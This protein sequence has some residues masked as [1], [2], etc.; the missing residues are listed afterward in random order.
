M[1]DEGVRFTDAHSP[2]TICSP[3][4]YGLFSGQH[5]TVLTG[6]GGGAFEGPGGPS[7]LK[8]G[9]LTLGDM[10]QAKGIPHRHLRQVACRA[11]LAGQGWQAA[12]RRLRERAAD[13]LRKEHAADRWPNRRGFHESL[14]TPN[15]P[16]TDPLYIYI[17][18]GR[19]PVP[20]SQRHQPES[21]P[22]PGGKWRWDNDAD[23]RHPDMSLCRPIF[24]FTTSC[25]G[26]S[27]GIARSPP[28]S[29]SSPSDTGIRHAP[30]LPA[31]GFEGATGAGPRGDFVRQLDT[32]VGRLLDL[33]VDPG[34]DG[35]T[36]VILNSDNGPET[37]HTVWMRQDLDHDA[38]GGWRGVKR[39]GWEG[40]HR[41]PFIVRWPD[42][43]PQG[44]V[45]DQM[46]STTD[47]FATLASACPIPLPRC[48][49]QR[50]AAFVTLF[51][52]GPRP[53]GPGEVDPAAPADPG[54]PRTVSDPPGKVEI[55]RSPGLGRQR[56]QTRTD[57]GV[58]ASRDRPRCAG[59]VVRPGE[60]PGG[61][62][63]PLFHRGSQAQGT[64]GTIG[65]VEV[66]RPKARRGT[67]SPSG[68]GT[69]QRSAAIKCM[70]QPRA[71]L[72]LLP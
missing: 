54:G 23:G 33:L 66:E 24:S 3:S 8:P 21:L 60:R 46:T 26:S 58:Y 42:R 70:S 43:I 12:H 56:L 28:K 11:D 48:R 27:P 14:I 9:T 67:G 71:P 51:A 10:L 49:S 31:A 72:A 20:A 25:S 53:A 15:C 37:F 13:R 29:R 2:S 1:A 63:Q 62:H 4:R 7:Y 5:L 35:Q 44:Q 16:T 18:N 52:G 32:L 68:S 61:N 34:I 30:V 50:P 41:V 36:M 64:Q 55:P 40:G 38:A 22:N 6:R 47:I 57:E 19:V 65:A 59:S 17:E 45:S 69:F 39:D